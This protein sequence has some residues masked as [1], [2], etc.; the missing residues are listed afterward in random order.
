MNIF[1][2]QETAINIIQVRPNKKHRICIVEIT[3]DQTI[4]MF[5]TGK[6]LL[7]CMAYKQAQH[8]ITIK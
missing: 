1:F 8:K 2:S 6:L 5:V 4:Y 3:M 7:R